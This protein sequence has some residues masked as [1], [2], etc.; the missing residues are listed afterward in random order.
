[1]AGRITLADLAVA[2]PFFNLQESGVPL[3]TGRWPRALAWVE[4]VLARPS[5]AP[6]V[7]NDRAFLA[8]TA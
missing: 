1:M 4:S 2:S 5:L 3:D 7:A 8:R 6:I